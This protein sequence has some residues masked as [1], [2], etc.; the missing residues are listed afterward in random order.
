ME[1]FMRGDGP[2]LPYTTSVD[3][4]HE[5]TFERPEGSFAVRAFGNVV[6]RFLQLL[7]SRIAGGDTADGLLAE[8]PAW[9][10]RLNAGL[11]N[12]GLAPA[13]AQREAPRAMAAL[14]N[15]VTDPIGR[16]ILA[17]NDGAASERPIAA[18]DS[19]VLRADRTFMA[20]AAPLLDG[21]GRVWIIDFKTSEQGSRSP[22]RFEKE[23]ILKYRAQLDRYAT[24]LRQL[25]GSSH[26]IVLGLYYPLI[27]RLLHW[28]S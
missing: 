13:F 22:E 23:E 26:E 1:R 25:S 12:E 28:S 8:L 17:A 11:R 18:P 7:A 21:N 2:R 3:L 20:G 27:P 4:P 19:T 10:P 5:P 9:E 6:H 16:W 15:A 24:V 14:R